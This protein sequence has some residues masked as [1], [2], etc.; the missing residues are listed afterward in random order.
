MR[1]VIYARYSSDNQ[2]DASIEDQVRVCRRL[3]EREGWE[4]VSRYADHAVSGASRFRSGYGQL[5]ADAE[6]GKF[7]IVVCEAIDRL[8]RKLADIAS[9]YDQLSYLGIR[10]HTIST[11]EVT[12]LHIGMLGTMAQLTLNDLRE[13]TKRGQLGRALDGKIPGGKA[14]GYDVL[15]ANRKGERGERGINEAEAVIVRRIFSDYADGRSPRAI[16]RALNAE[17]IPGPDGREWRN[18]TIRG[19]VDRG[20]GILNNALYVGRLEWNR[21]SYVKNPKT[22]KRVARI[23]PPEQWEVVDI[24]HLRI[25]DDGLWKRAKRR[26][27]QVRLEMGRDGAGNALNRAHRRRYMFSG[28]LECG[29]CGG[30]YIIIRQDQYGCATH[31]SRGTCD[32]GRTILRQE[33]EGR[34]LVGLK[35]RLLAP[36]LFEAFAEEF[37]RQINQAAAEAEVQY[38][39]LEKGLA[40]VER[41]IESM[42]KAI[43]DGMYSPAMK[44]RMAELEGRRSELVSRIEA[45][46]DPTPIRLHPNLNKIYTEKVANLE[47]ALNRDDTRTEAGEIIRSLVDR[48]VLTP[49]DDGIR[50][51]L[52]G[53]FA[54]I[55]AL[56]DPSTPKNELPGSDEPVSQLSVVAGTG[57]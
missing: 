56:C 43:E 22:G 36:E 42:L 33:I 45:K 17:A 25:V 57:S 53:D 12:A 24:P 55:L 3:I 13:K 30:S 21:C 6:Q 10:I 40:S 32:N 35:D 37:H 39:G 27:Q 14:Y 54:S 52:H 48:I 8:G 2:R 16:A 49:V 31:R 7:D 11:G 46:P 5:L 29:V 1:A 38:V 51:E 41:K 20:T 47:E 18:T 23:N 50:A 34:V 28:V 19:Q 9:L 15:P 26:Q 4:L 44:E